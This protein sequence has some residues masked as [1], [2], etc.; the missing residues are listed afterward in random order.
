NFFI[1]KGG[2]LSGTK[3]GL[4]FFTLHGNKTG[5]GAGSAHTG[6]VMKISA[7]GKK[8][9]IIAAGLRMPYIGLNRTTG[10]LTASDQQGSYVPATPIYHVTRG[11][12]FGVPLTAHQEKEPNISEPITWIPHRVDRSSVSQTW[13]DSK[14]MG[15]LNGQ[16]V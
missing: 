2:H 13:I 14:K 1:A 4:P 11:D 7:D 15:P 6:T 12:Y 9:E 5:Y 8:A 16:T 3:S 10:F